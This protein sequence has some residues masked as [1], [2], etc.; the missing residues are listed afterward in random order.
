MQ[1]D[2]AIKIYFPATSADVLHRLTEFQPN[3]LYERILSYPSVSYLE[4]C[5]PP[6]AL[7]LA[8]L[9]LFVSF[10]RISVE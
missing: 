4:I 6:V 8:F 10:G 1:R 5:I 2:Q 3:W 7:N 9:T